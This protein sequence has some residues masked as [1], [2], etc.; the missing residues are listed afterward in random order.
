ME[1]WHGIPHDTEL[2]GEEI[3][4]LTELVMKYVYAR[5]PDVSRD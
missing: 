5:I 2:G 3:D 4:Y 1:Y